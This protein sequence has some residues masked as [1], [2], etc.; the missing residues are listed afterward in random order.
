MGTTR[1]N[2]YADVS[3]AFAAPARETEYLAARVKGDD[4]DTF[5]QTAWGLAGIGVFTACLAVAFWFVRD[6]LNG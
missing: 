3:L 2:G 6:A 1:S 5:I 4:M